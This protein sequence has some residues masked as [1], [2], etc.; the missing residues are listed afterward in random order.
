MYDYFYDFFDGKY[1]MFHNIHLQER[2]PKRY[3]K[4]IDNPLESYHDTE[5][6]KIFAKII[7]ICF[8]IMGLI[9]GQ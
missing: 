1:N 7:N 9:I 5:F 2:V 4:E 8:R 6:Y 3:I